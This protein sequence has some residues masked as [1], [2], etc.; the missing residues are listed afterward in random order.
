MG[1]QREWLRGEVPSWERD[2]LIS[3]EQSQAI[4]ARYP[5]PPAGGLPWGMIIF[6]CLGAVIVGL[7]LILL[8]AYNWDAISKY[9]KL[10]L[11]FGTLAA[12]H[13]V[14][15]R[16]CLG[17]ERFRPLGEGICLL[18]TMLFGAGI[19]LVAQIYLFESQ[20]TRGLIFVVMGALLLTE[21]FLYSR[22]KKQKL[23][24]GAQ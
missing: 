18:G 17:R 2:G 6:S 12:V 5:A 19:W 1:D 22:T 8:L 3:G 21:G 9:G 10:T 20:L 15:L 4:L 11:V 16:L 7:G 24:G 14:G 13:V 23:A